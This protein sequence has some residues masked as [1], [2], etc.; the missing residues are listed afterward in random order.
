MTDDDDYGAIDAMSE[1]QGKMNYSDK[2]CPI[3]V[4]Y[5]THLI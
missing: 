1:W 2:T 5:T 3:A 4:L